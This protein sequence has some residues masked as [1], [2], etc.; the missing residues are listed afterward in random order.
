MAD[1]TIVT[2]LIAH[3]RMSPELDKAGKS[4]DRAGDKFKGLGS[5][6]KGVAAGVGAAAGGALAVGFAT[7][8]SFDAANDKL[9]AQMGSSKASAAVLGKAAGEVYAA[10]WG[11]SIDQV[12]EGIRSVINNIGDTGP[13]SDSLQHVTSNVL[14]LSQAFD[15][16]LGGATAA[17]GQM[18]KTGM[19]DSAQEALDVITRGFQI[20]VDKSGDFL[21]TLN[22]YGVQFQKLG[23]DGAT[24][25]GLLSQGLQAGA[26]DADIVAD[27]LKEFAIRAV[28]GS[29]LTAQGFKAIGLNGKQMSADIAAGGPRASKALQATLDA[30]RGIQDPAKRSQAAVALFGTQAEDLGDALYSLDLNTTA[31]NM[32][33]VAGSADAMAAQLGDNAAAKVDSMKRSFQAW[34]AEMASSESTLGMVTT[35]GVQFGG[36]A[37][38]LGSNLATVAVAFK[39]VGIGAKLA[40][41]GTKAAAAAQWLLN[42]ALTANPIGLVIAA[43]ALLAVAFV[44]AWKKSQKFREVVTATFAKVSSV[45]LKGVG[46]VLKY[47]KTMANVWLTT[48]GAILTGA[49][50]AFG[51]IPGIGPKLKSAKTEFEKFKTGVNSAFDKAIAKTKEWDGA[52]DRLPKEVKLKGEISDL[53]KKI[54]AGKA[55]LKTLPPEKQTKAKADIA[56]LQRQVDRAKAKLRTLKNRTVTVTYK[57]RFTGGLPMVVGGPALGQL[58]RAKGGPVTKGQPYIVGDGGRPELF[59]PQESGTILPRVPSAAPTGGVSAASAGAGGSV[60][61]LT[62]NVT[63]PLGTPQQVATAVVDAFERRPAGGRRIP[64]TAVAGR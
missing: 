26:R 56:Q 35:A 31:V 19:A 38:S 41:V 54:D 57:T 39:G 25:T 15:Q 12:N 7:S 42:A 8:V 2:D 24:A 27:A 64:A 21:D 5:V 62:V 29:K 55:K 3:D 50:K 49:E 9:A 30:L 61:N 18:M 51:W 45:V 16:D 47:F 48:A 20:G 14:A 60:I 6:L 23:L 53:T 10:G 32:G 40:A 44:V 63:A 33:K 46:L 34:T 22:E 4:A 52:V 28:D 11:D 17:V 13:A 36:Q 58:L 59:V 1:H 43:I 37:L